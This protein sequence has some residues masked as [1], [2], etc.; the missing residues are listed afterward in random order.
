MKSMCTSFGEECKGLTIKNAH[1]SGEF[2]L[3]HSFIETFKAGGLK[4]CPDFCFDN[5]C[6]IKLFRLIDSVLL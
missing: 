5:L 4:V 1:F 2:V 3:L 6:F